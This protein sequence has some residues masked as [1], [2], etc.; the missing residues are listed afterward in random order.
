MEK[1]KNGAYPSKKPRQMEDDEHY[2]KLFEQFVDQHRNAFSV[3]KLLEE[4]KSEAF[5]VFMSA[6]M[7]WIVQAAPNKMTLNTVESVVLAKMC[8][9]ARKTFPD[10]SCEGLEGYSIGDMTR[11]FAVFKK[12]HDQLGRVHGASKSKVD[13]T[14]PAF[15][16][17]SEYLMSSVE[18]T[19]IGVCWSAVIAVLSCTGISTDTL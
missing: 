13:S 2:E 15:R 3:Q 4:H 1:Q 18:P 10:L 14:R 7:C 11:R 12:M 5:G 16:V 9:I 17:D 8:K 6:V 19:A